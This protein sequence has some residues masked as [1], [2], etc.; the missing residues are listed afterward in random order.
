M[1]ELRPVVTQELP[2]R[3][4]SPATDHAA[5]GL[6]V[7]LGATF[8]EAGKLHHAESAFERAV[9]T[10]KAGG[11]AS[12]GDT[13]MLDHHLTHLERLR[14][15]RTSDRPRSGHRPGGT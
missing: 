7:A 12:H 13:V 1:G 3:S 11:Y 5:V 8:L 15:S 10:I 6:L 14:G 4:T 9:M 2:H